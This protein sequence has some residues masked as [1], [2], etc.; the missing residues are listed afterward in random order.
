MNEIKESPAI[1]SLKKIFEKREKKKEEEEKNRQKLKDF[2]EEMERVIKE[3]VGI[4]TEA[5]EEVE[6][7]FKNGVTLFFRKGEWSFKE[8]LFVR[9]EELC[10][11]G[12]I[13]TS[14]P[15]EI[16][17]LTQNR[18]VS[19]VKITKTTQEG[20]KEEEYLSIYL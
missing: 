14:R 9:E 2:L 20:E 5:I 1:S 19:N 13:V 18:E 3:N 6:I 15:K 16:L 11:N 8:S 4:D 7:E 10:K 17:E 12:S